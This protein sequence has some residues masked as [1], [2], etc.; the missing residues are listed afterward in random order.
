M[1]AQIVSSDMANNAI[2]AGLHYY[3]PNISVE[4][5]IDIIVALLGISKVAQVAYK[6]WTTDGT[7]LDKIV[8]LVGVVQEPTTT[9]VT[10][11]T[12]TA[13]GNGPT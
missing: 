4:Q 9:V 1:L 6:H 3:L 8:K 5:I 11:T 2:A 13:S 7:K 12:K 10:P